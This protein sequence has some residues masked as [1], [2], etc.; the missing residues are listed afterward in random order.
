VSTDRYPHVLGEEQTLD[1]VL[2]G[3]SLARYGDG[4]FHLCSGIGIPCQRY[5]RALQMRLVDILRDSGECKVGLPNIHSDTPKA[6][7]WE[8]FASI[9]PRF[10]SDRRYVSAFISRPDSAPWIDTPSYWSQL[11]SLWRDQDVTLVR[12]SSRSLTSDDLK[13]A[14]KV[15]EVIAPKRDAWRDYDALLERIGTPARALLCLGPTATVM[16]VDLCAKGVHAI[17]IGHVGLF[18]KKHRRGE[19]MTVTEADKVSR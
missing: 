16:A 18:L 1:A 5:D 14:K 17:D 8:P 12:G 11:E 3:W 9:A 6:S 13:G 4:E 2:H 10:L 7:F 19:S 15:T